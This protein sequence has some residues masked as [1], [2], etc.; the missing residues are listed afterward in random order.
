MPETILS[1]SVSLPVALCAVL[2][3]Y[4]DSL[5]EVCCGGLSGAEGEL[6]VG[7]VGVAIKPSSTVES[8]VSA[9][10]AEGVTEGSYGVEV[11]IGIKEMPYPMVT[12]MFLV[13]MLA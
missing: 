12:E 7:D 2:S 13:Y 6:Q 3:D 9:L 4:G 5:Y 1:E 8:L 10:A 11:G